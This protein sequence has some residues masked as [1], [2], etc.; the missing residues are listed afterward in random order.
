MFDWEN[1]VQTVWDVLQTDDAINPGSS[2]GPLIDRYGR[3]IGVTTLKLGGSAEA[4]GF[5][6]S[7]QIDDYTTAGIPPGLHLLRAP[8]GEAGI[9]ETSE[10]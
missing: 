3:V 8:G 10:Q 7:I 4:I 6:V 5:A 1:W 2:G 9:T